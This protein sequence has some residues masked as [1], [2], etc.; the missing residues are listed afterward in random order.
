[1]TD[2]TQVSPNNYKTIFENDHVRVV[3]AKWK[4]GEKDE[5]HSHPS[6]VIYAF[7]DA[8]IKVHSPDG[9]SKDLEV[10]AG[11]AMYQDPIEAHS[12]ENTGSSDVHILLLELK[13]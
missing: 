5:M 7:N 13:K 3:D 12:V 4:P 2:P 10:S 9:S 1:M 6:L 11:T 8:K